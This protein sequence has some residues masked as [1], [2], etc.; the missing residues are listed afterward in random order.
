MPSIF[1][2][3]GA[4]RIDLR[5]VGCVAGE[6]HL[7]AR[8]GGLT[9]QS[10]QRDLSDQI[11]R[12]HRREMNIPESTISRRAALSAGLA[13]TATIA[14][15]ATATAGALTPDP[16]FAAIE[17]ARR[18]DKVQDEVGSGDQEIDDA[19]HNMVEARSAL[20]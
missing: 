4:A 18:A 10:P 20:A 8:E 14:A 12:R 7:V 19:Y 2:V 16:I 9:Q 13:A 1:L 6:A 11:V 5:R 15:G 17:R 3:N